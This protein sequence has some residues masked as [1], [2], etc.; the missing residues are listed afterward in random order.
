M[1]FII[2]D[3]VLDIL[4]FSHIFFVMLSRNNVKNQRRR[5]RERERE[6][7]REGKSEMELRKR[8]NHV[9]FGCNIVGTFIIN[10]SIQL[11][12]TAAFFSMMKFIVLCCYIVVAVVVVDD[13][14]VY[15]CLIFCQNKH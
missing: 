1:I 12:F 6:R 5:G 7:E 14:Y 4:I 9:G 10:Y 8:Y 2:I 11:H 3:F 15:E 13:V